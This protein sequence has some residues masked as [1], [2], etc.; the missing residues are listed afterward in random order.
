MVLLAVEKRNPRGCVTTGYIAKKL[1][2]KS[3][4]YLRNILFHMVEIGI[5]QEMSTAPNNGRGDRFRAWRV[6]HYEMQSL[7]AH[8]IVINVRG[9]SFVETLIGGF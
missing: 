6:A 3:S 2:I 9:R 7:P 8:D 5:V 4:T 1:G